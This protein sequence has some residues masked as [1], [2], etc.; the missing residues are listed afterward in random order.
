MKRLVTVLAGTFVIF[1]LTIGAVGA[2]RP[3]GR[4][5]PDGSNHLSP[6]APTRITLPAAQPAT[7]CAALQ[8]AYAGPG[9]H[10]PA[11]HRRMKHAINTRRRSTVT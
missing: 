6:A 11:E 10:Q 2:A 3:I 1:L 7:T 9:L 8:L 4:R 5:R